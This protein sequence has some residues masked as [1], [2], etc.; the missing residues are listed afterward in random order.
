MAEE[1]SESKEQKPVE[2]EE[3]V[4]ASLEQKLAF[5]T[6]AVVREM[7]RYIAKDKMIR[8]EVKLAM[9]KFLADIVKDISQSIDKFPYSVVD[10]RMFEDAIKPY[11]RVKDLQ[12][13]KRRLVAHLDSIIEDCASVKRDLDIKFGNEEQ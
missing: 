5:P 9:N 11:K 2:A 7:K 1:L 13:E 10:Y 12:G 4:D 8:K 3:E 6:A